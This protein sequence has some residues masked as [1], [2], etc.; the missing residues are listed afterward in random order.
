[1]RPRVVVFS[2]LLVSCMLCGVG[3]AFAAGAGAK[4]ATTNFV[5]TRIQRDTSGNIT[6]NNSTSGSK[7]TVANNPSTSNIT[8]NS[9]EVA[10][11]G[12]ADSNRTSKV[13]DGQ[14]GSTLVDMWIE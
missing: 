7:V 8:T 4:I 11:V 14:S 9:K 6:I 13:R 2:F 10:T 1:M 3:T 12:W 5:D